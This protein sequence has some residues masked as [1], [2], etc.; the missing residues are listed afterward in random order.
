MSVVQ[1]TSWY[2]VFSLIDQWQ[3]LKIY[4]LIRPVGWYFAPHLWGQ[5]PGFSPHGELQLLAPN[6]QTV[7]TILQMD[8]LRFGWSYLIPK[9]TSQKT[10]QKSHRTNPPFRRCI[11]YQKQWLFHCHV[12]FS[13][14]FFLDIWNYIAIFNLPFLYIEHHSPKPIHEATP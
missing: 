10:F 11:S 4:K 14:I 13:G 3:F 2:D 8:W 1:H 5:V 6:K 7:P 9:S 12:S